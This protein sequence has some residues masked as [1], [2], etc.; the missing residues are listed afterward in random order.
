MPIAGP[1]LEAAAEPSAAAFAAPP[2]PPDPYTGAPTVRS[3]DGRFVLTA[4]TL[5]IRGQ[6]FALRELG[7]ADLL[8]VRWLLWYLLGALGLAGVMITYLQNG[9]RTVPAMAGMAG[10]ALLLAY[11]QR[12]TNRLRLFRLGRETAHFAL[13]GETLPWQRLTAELNRRI[14]HAHDR[15]AAEATA[16]LAAVAAAK[17]AAEAAA[18]ATA[19]GPGALGG[20][21]GLDLPASNLYLRT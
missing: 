10:A 1:H 9:L 18:A 2:L 6:A 13:P 17:A 19:A 21:P 14:G 16:V 15:V 12:G 7:R 8:R 11:G 5:T 20:L 4:T 3:P